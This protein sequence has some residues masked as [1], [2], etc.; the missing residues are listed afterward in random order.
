MKIRQL[1]AELFQAEGLMDGHDEVNILFSQF[2][3]C[4]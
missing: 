3:E 4:V 2:F 1:R